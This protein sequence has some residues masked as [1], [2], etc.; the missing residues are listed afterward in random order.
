MRCC[1]NVP[2]GTNLSLEEFIGYQLPPVV[3]RVASELNHAPPLG[4]Y[5]SFDFLA[6]PHPGGQLNALT[7]QEL[8]KPQQQLT[9]FTALDFSRISNLVRFRT[10]VSVSV[11]VVA[12]A[13]GVPS[14]I[15]AFHRY[16]STL[17]HTLARRFRVQ[18]PG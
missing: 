18:F 13:T 14:Y 6:M 12:F 3:L 8:R 2:E 1:L 7:H 9:S 10:S 17:Y 16:C 4:S 15:Y 11:R 5:R